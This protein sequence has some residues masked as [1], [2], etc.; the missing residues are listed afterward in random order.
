[1]LS[2]IKFRTMS[3]AKDKNG[4]TALDIAQEHEWDKLIDLLTKYNSFTSNT[5]DPL[6]KDYIDLFNSI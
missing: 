3:N 2:L 5:T 1:M 4:R 6:T